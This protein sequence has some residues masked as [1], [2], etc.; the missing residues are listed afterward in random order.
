MIIFSWGAPPKAIVSTVD[1]FKLVY[2]RWCAHFVISRLPKEE[3]EGV[4]MRASILEEYLATGRQ[5]WQHGQWKTDYIDNPEFNMAVST[6]RTKEKEGL[7]RLLFAAEG[8]LFSISLNSTI[9]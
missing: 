6:L 2:R 1:Y 7:G 5:G 9:F 8:I 4:K 3:H